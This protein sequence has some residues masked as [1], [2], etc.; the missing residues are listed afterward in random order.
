M[1]CGSAGHIHIAQLPLTTLRYG[2][3]S[4]IA[5]RK[6]FVRL[7]AQPSPPAQP[8]SRQCLSGWQFS[9][10]WLST[11]PTRA[12][13]ARDAKSEHCT[14]YLSIA[15]QNAEFKCRFP[16]ISGS[17]WFDRAL[18]CYVMLCYVMLC[19]VM[20]CHTMPWPAQLHSLAL[21]RS[22]V[23]RYLHVWSSKLLETL[24]RRCCDPT[25]LFL[26]I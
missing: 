13:N 12:R 1:I 15:W 5:Y 4:H 3:C 14:I 6:G 11:F 19:Y 10:F 22:L 21:P 8:S 18:P 20:P 23:P 17:D 24:T 2:G 25:R 7:Q 9:N 16:A 26:Q